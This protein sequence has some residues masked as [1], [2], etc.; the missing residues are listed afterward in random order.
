MALVPHGP[1]LLE[2]PNPLRN[3]ASAGR[4]GLGQWASAMVPAPHGRKLL[5][6]TGPAFHP[7]AMTRISIAGPVMVALVATL[8]VG[9]GQQTTGQR[10]ASPST[11]LTPPSPSVSTSAPA[12]TPPP[13]PPRTSSPARPPAA[14]ALQDGRYAA[15]LT[16]INTTAGTITFDVVQFLTGA[17]A[18]EAYRRDHPGD[19]NSEAPDGFYIVN[20]NPLLR[21]LPVRRDAPV[22]I[23]W[24]RGSSSDTRILTLDQLPGYFASEHGD[25]GKYLWSNPFWLTVRGDVVTAMDE[26]YLP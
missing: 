5:A 2:A 4:R 17:A 1:K 7:A 11:T 8:L 15:Y 10:P 6:R 9:C 22:R 26:Q 21:T 16:A 20:A 25:Y 12:S 18:D 13:A 19:N 14:A 24:P 23:F 3:N